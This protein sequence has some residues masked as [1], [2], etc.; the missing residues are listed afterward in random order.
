MPARTF[1]SGARVLD[2]GERERFDTYVDASYDSFLR[3]VADGRRMDVEAVHEVAQGRVWSGSDALDRG[4]VDKLGGFQ[5]ALETLRA[6]V[7]PK[8]AQL[9]P[10]VVSLESAGGALALTTFPLLDALGAVALGTGIARF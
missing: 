1:H 9:E 10:K 6:A 3:A 4:L 7:G 2:P 8:A 5:T